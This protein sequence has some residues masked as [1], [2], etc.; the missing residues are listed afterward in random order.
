VAVLA[1]HLHLIDGGYLGVDLFFTLSGFLITSLLVAEWTARGTIDFRAFWVR[2][3]RR[4]VPAVLLVLVAVGLATRTWASATLFDQVRHDA[5]ATLAYVANWRSVAAGTDYW[6]LFARP[7]PLEHTWSLAI[8]EQFYVV[9]PVVAG[10]LL[11]WFGRRPPTPTA[12][13]RDTSTHADADA[14]EALPT[15]DT[16]THAAIADRGAGPTSAAG[17]PA[18]AG[19]G[20]APVGARSR[21]GPPSP[22]LVR[23]RLDRFLAVTVGLAVASAVVALVRYRSAE[24]ANRVYF[25]TDTRAA[26]IL[27]GAALAIATARFGALAGRRARAALEVAAALALAGLVWAWFELRGTDDRLYQ[28]GLLACGLAAT[29]VLAAV[30]HPTRGPLARVLSFPP[31]RWIGLISYGLYLWHWPIITFFTPGR[32]GVYGTG[33]LLWRVGLSV[34]F[35]AASYFAFEKPIRHG[36]GR[37]WPMRVATPLAVVAVVCAVV[38]STDGG[39]KPFGAFGGG[40][41]KLRIAA[42]PVPPVSPDRPRLLVVG[43]SGAWALQYPLE[44]VAAERRIDWV[45]RGTPACGIARGDGR[46]RQPDGR[47]LVDPP[48]C[49][50]WPRRWNWYLG[51]V[52]PDVALVFS[53][54]PAGAARWLEGEW[55]RDCDPVFD[56]WYQ[57]EYEHGLEVLGRTGARVAVTTIA[58]LDS[59]S[60][61]DGR[62]PQADCRNETIRRAAAATGAQLVDLYDWA[63]PNGRTCR[64]TVRTRS[65]REVEL[66]PDGLHYSGPGGIVATRWILDQLGLVA[67]A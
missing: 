45:D 24:D 59:D 54:A 46:S 7:S 2:R 28:G 42:T 19:A 15:S 67:P 3:A 33:L 47:I 48:G 13:P 12:D 63:C 8:E 14:D 17:G 55:R 49:R 62:F 16:A 21:P 25:G 23:H 26:A 57:S 31:L 51:R 36:L 66:R 60:D 50:D 52:Q 37:G 34:A 65:G 41:N 32:T 56:R 30:S 58:Y 5:L 43:D 53:V 38:W 35:A 29:L 6:N 22:E 18:D 4:L 44:P 61:F 64:T 11:L 9:W 1:F 27:F 20:A 39:S 10:A 40:R